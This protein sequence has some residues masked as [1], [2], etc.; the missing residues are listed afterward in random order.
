MSLV[1]G[2]R[3]LNKAVTTS[4]ILSC[5]WGNLI[6]SCYKYSQRRVRA[7]IEVLWWHRRWEKE[8]RGEERTWVPQFCMIR[9]ISSWTS[10]THLSAGS[11][12]RFIWRFTSNS[13]DTSGT[14]SAGRVPWNIGGYRVWPYYRSDLIT[15]VCLYQPHNTAVHTI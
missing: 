2:S 1:I 9:C 10:S 14:N 12:N 13:N 4:T 7:H 11:S 5:N 3:L 8:G 15:A 6:I